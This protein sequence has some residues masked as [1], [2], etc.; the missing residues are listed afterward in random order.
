MCVH[1]CVLGGGEGGDSSTSVALCGPQKVFVCCGEAEERS[2]LFECKQEVI[3]TTLKP[4]VEMMIKYPP[5]KEL[6]LC[7]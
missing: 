5:P 1:P 7:Q 2:A 3:T 4:I 6:L